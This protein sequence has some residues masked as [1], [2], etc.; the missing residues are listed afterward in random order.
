M[1]RFLLK[2][3]NIYKMSN[4]NT[5]NGFAIGQNSRLPS[6]TPQYE[7]ALVFTPLQQPVVPVNQPSFSSPQIKEFKSPNPI[8][9]YF[10]GDN[11]TSPYPHTFHNQQFK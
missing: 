2:I 1:S 10:C 7:R 5:I 6:S 9:D 4:N 3:K 8:S 11:H